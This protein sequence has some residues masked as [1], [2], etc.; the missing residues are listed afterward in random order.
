MK[1]IFTP[2]QIAE[3]GN[4]PPFYYGLTHDKYDADY[5][6]WHIIPF[7]YIIRTIKRIECEWARVRT[8]R[9]WI[10]YEII[11]A[12]DT[13]NKKWKERLETNKYLRNKIFN[14]VFDEVCRKAECTRIEF[15][16]ER[17][18]HE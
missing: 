11:R 3:G 5:S 10:D 17:M 12:I 4:I 7:N 9:G 6:V 14:E 2:R 1:K 16:A 15:E 18:K 13:N 8:K